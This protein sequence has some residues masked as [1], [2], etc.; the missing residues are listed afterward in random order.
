MFR[1]ICLRFSVYGLKFLVPCFLFIVSFFLFLMIAPHIIKPANAQYSATMQPVLD[2]DWSGDVVT[3]HW[4]NPAVPNTALIIRDWDDPDK[5]VVYDS[6]ADYGSIEGHTSLAVSTTS[7]HILVHPPDGRFHVYL[8][9]GLSPV[10]N[11]VE[12][13][14]PSGAPAW[15]ID[16]PPT[17][18]GKNVTFHWAPPANSALALIIVDWDDPLHT[19]VWDSEADGSPINGLDTVTVNTDAWHINRAIS[20]EPDGQF[21]VTLVAY[22]TDLKS[23]R[24]IFTVGS[25]KNWNDPGPPP[26]PFDIMD[27]FQPAKRFGSFGQLASDVLLILVSLAGALA[28]IFI[29][30]SGFKFVTSSGDEKKLASARATLTYAIIG[31]AVV[32]LAFVIVQVLQYFLQ[33]SVPIT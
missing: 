14:I 21:A 29:M 28:M 2:S 20:P 5:T 17:W 3:F 8:N 6:G 4:D 13:T 26:P 12:F 24:V 22:G 10:S 16:D 15:L 32:I 31:I 30:L 18:S 25:G 11:E 33:S 9:W 7:W 23:N 19:S 1:K 27:V